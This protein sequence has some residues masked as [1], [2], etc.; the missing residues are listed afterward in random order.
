M[1]S[2]QYYQTNI[3]SNKFFR[4]ILLQLSDSD[5]AS[6]V[7][8]YEAEIKE[9]KDEFFRLSWYMRGGVTAD[10][11]FYL[12]GYE[13]RSIMNNIIKEN[14]ELTKKTGTNFL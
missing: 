6:V 5:I 12:Y 8:R 2:G 4:L 9:L 3:G 7:D 13:D 14:I 1:W 11:M 10:Q